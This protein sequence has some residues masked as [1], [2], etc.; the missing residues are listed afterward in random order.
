VS[1]TVEETGF[2]FSDLDNAEVTEKERP[3]G[4]SRSTTRAAAT[5][6]R[7]GRKP[8]QS[9]LTDLQKKLSG[10]MF[11]AGAL[12]GLPLP[13]TG[14]YIAQESN[15]FTVALVELASYRPEWINALEQIA[16]LEPGMVIGR[17]AIGIGAAAAVDRKRA[18]PDS[19][20][21]AFLGVKQAYDAIQ[22]KRMPG[23][24]DPNASSY[25][26]PPAGTFTPV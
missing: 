5:G 8:R 10:E 1:E 20:V 12:V 7:R 23:E 18:T 21:M 14:Y 19:F 22:A 6:A 4:T 16:K 2:D 25:S 26:P 11:K 24:V 17:T 13:V 15:D 3:A 9:R